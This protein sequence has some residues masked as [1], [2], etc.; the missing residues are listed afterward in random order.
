MYQKNSSVLLASMMTGLT[1]KPPDFA[2]AFLTQDIKAEGNEGFK[3]DN[4]GDK[5]TDGDFQSL[6]ISKDD[7]I[8][9]SLIIPM[10][11]DYLVE[12]ILVQGCDGDTCVGTINPSTFTVGQSLLVDGN[13]SCGGTIT[14]NSIFTCGL[15]GKN[16]GIHQGN[17]DQ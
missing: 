1:L 3:Q 10:E 13:P 16:I 6:T 9:H 4:G 2:S 11:Y 15:K 8:E 5:L 14:A 17:T 12:T 7:P